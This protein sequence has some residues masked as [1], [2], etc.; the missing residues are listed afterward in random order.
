M[1]SKTHSRVNTRLCKIVSTSKR[2]VFNMLSPDSSSDSLLS[3]TVIAVG[4]AVM[5]VVVPMI[6]IHSFGL[7]ALTPI[8]GY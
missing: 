7:N 8:Y 5:L 3:G 2:S 1:S 4:A 6:L